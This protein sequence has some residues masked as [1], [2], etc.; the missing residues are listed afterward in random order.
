[1]SNKGS[2]KK[3]GVYSKLS[4]KNTPKNDWSLSL[5]FEK[6]DSISSI[7]TSQILP[8]KGKVII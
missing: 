4:G 6:D 2:Q 8:V 7:Q 5:G 1:M 3:T